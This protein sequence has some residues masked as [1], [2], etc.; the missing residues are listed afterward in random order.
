MTHTIPVKAGWAAGPSPLNGATAE[1]K[2]ARSN[3]MN[4]ARPHHLGPDGALR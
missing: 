2:A 3:E 4:V 1:E